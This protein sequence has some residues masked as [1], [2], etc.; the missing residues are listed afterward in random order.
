MLTALRQSDETKQIAWTAARGDGFVCPECGAPVT[1]KQGRKVAAHFAHKPPVSCEYGSGES[2]VHFECKTE[3][4]NELL[5]RP[6]VASCELERG[7]GSVR[8]DISFYYN[9]TPIAIEVQKSTISVELAEKRTREYAAKGIYLLWLQ[10]LMYL[11]E[12]YAPKAWEKWTHTLYYGRVYSW[13]SG[14]QIAPAKFRPAFIHVEETEF[15]G[16]Y[17]KLSK[18]WRTV[19]CG[20]AIDL[21]DGFRAIERAAFEQGGVSVPAA[22]LWVGK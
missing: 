18:R 20:D 22:R 16:G 12:R 15:G 3:I 1:L 17:D 13:L 9:G 19:E 8:P 5:R 7:L 11:P 10:P 6:G 4:Y 2:S 14:L 21:L